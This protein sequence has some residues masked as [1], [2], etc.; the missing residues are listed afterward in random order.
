MAAQG[1]C[2]VTMLF[3]LARTNWNGQAQRAKELTSSDYDEEEL[4]VEKWNHKDQTDNC[5][6]STLS[7]NNLDGSDL[8]V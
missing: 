1:S 5:V 6:D 3:V 4:L 7:D 8:A 2:M